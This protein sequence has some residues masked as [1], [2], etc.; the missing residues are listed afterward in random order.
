LAG[1]PAAMVPKLA[2]IWFFVPLC[3]FDH[4]ASYVLNHVAMLLRFLPNKR[5]KA[6]DLADFAAEDTGLPAP[7]RRI[8]A[9]FSRVQHLFSLT[10]NMFWPRF[11][12]R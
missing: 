5:K 7:S 3:Q 6:P 2:S 11:T 4:L 9:P 10:T 8:F 12:Q 1:E